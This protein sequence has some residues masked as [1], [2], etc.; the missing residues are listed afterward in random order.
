VVV[1]GA[2]AG[3][4]TPVGDGRAV[5][6]LTAATIEGPVELLGAAGEGEGAV[7]FELRTRAR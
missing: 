2:P 3:A 4:P 1:S 6:D 7:R 5:L